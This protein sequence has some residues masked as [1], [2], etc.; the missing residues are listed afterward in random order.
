MS[1]HPAPS[2]S[3]LLRVI[4][5]AWL[6]LISGFVVIDR[7]AVS[8]LT[9]RV[10][11]NFDDLLI[12]SLEEKV[13]ALEQQVDALEHAPDP[14]THEAFASTRLALDQRLVQL[15]DV[16]RGAAS[17]SDVLTLQQRLSAVETRLSRAQAVRPT[18]PPRAPATEPTDTA[19]PD[20]PFT[21]LG[22][23]W[24]GGK[25]F[26]SLVPAGAYSLE[27]VHVLQPG[28]SYEDWQLETVD[29]S[30]AVFRVAG[31]SQRVTIP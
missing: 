4:S 5:I 24:R 19:P 23:E 7:V 8:R 22:I 12:Q 30:A 18:L 14:V 27:G 2:R 31:R 11:N 16:V 17:A 13:V 26:L 3:R 15:E 25:Y 20:P 1:D 28:E 6:A 29:R 9:E 10:E 21:V